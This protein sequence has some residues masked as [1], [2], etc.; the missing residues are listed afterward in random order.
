MTDGKDLDRQAALVTGASSGIGRAIATTLATA[1]ADVVLVARRAEELD[2]V[3]SEIVS[4]GGRAATVVADLSDPEQV[5]TVVD[6]A[7]GVLGRLDVV[8]NAAGRADWASALETDQASFDAHLTLNTWVPLRLAQL[9]HPY[10]S[11]SAD[12]VVVMVGSVDAARPSSGA[13]A[14][15]ASKGAM[16]SLTVVLAKEW[17]SDGIRVVQVDPGLVRTPMAAEVVGKVNSG[18]RKINL[19]GRA[20]EPTEVAALVLYLVSPSGRF[21]TGTSF[22]LDGGALA[23]GPFDL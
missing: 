18:E 16:S 4:Q 21:A 22:R 10:L 13:A 9:A 23:A 19:V 8:V 3:A 15:G 7:V 11:E 20:G 2:V 1:G 12:G 5:D 14:Y 6:R 17:A